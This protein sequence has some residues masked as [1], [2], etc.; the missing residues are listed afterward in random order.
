MRTCV[1]SVVIGLALVAV[2]GSGEPPPANPPYYRVHYEPSREPGELVYGVSYTIWIPPGV[3]TLRGVIVHQHGCGEGACKAGETA[4]FDLHW[5]ALAKKHD[6]ALL[7]PSYEQPEKANCALWCDPRNGSE[8]RFLQTLEDLGKKSGHP[9]LAAVPWAL[10]GHSGGGQW[11][12][13]ML[14]RHPQRIAAVWLRSG[15]PRLLQ[16]SDSPLPPVTIPDGAC[17]VP[18]MFNLGTKEGVTVKEGRFAGVWDRVKSFFEAMRAKGA[19]AGVAVDPFSSHDCGNCRYLAI[20]WFDA[21]LTDRLGKAGEPV[22]KPM[23]QNGVWLAELLDTRAQPAGEFRGDL[24]TSVWLPD[25][26]IAKLWMEYVRDAKVTD[27][28]PPPPPTDVRVGDHGRIT[29]KAEADVESG[30]ARFIIER[31]GQEIARLPETPKNPFGRPIF[32]GNSYSDTPV[33]PLAEMTFT[34]PSPKSGA[35]YRI[36]SVNTVGLK[37]TPVEATK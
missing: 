34:D 31:D 10:W 12:G 2:S 36:I 35:R 4:A 29:W 7:G 25:Q 3:K 8:K 13:T 5:Q 17:A 14:V 27:E 37:S 24:K 18:V 20:P 19:L 32:Q 6:C 16:T 23:P 9:E 22:L 28:T 30:L 1:L 21:C 33:P 26:R 15:A 11:V